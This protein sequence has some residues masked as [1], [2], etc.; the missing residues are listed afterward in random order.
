[1]GRGGPHDRGYETALG[2]TLER[3][4]FGQPLA[5]FQLVQYKLAD[6]L[7]RTTAS[8]W[9]AY[10]TTRRQQAGA[11][12]PGQASL[13]KMHTARDARQVLLD[14]RDLLGGQGVLLEHHVGRHL[15]DIEGL[16]SYGGTDHV[17]ALVV[18]RE[19]TGHSAFT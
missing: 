3:E 14:A 9:L 6:M 17:Q 12:T 16:Y 7:A 18:G 1:M 2:Y 19:V 4:Q 8:L 13:A 5:A 10:R 11:L 15:A